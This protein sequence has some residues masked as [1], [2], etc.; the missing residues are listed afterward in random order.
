MINLTV[1]IEACD[2]YEIYDT[3][4]LPTSPNIADAFTEVEDNKCLEIFTA[5]GIFT[6]EICSGL[7]GVTMVL[8]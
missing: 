8:T 6:Q 1:A 4:W 7:L 2:T 3:G 5:T